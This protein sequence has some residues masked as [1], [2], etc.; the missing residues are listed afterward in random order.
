MLHICIFSSVGMF[1]MARIA[2][3]QKTM[4]CS[5]SILRL[6]L[7]SNAWL[8]R[9][10]VCSSNSRCN[11]HFIVILNR[12]HKRSFSILEFGLILNKKVAQNKHIRLN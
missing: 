10:G 8:N 2:N 1:G 12:L 7:K 9:F 5:R 11:Q 6:V 4:F 3:F